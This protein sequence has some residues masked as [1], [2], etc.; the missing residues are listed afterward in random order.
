MMERSRRSSAWQ[1]SVAALERARRHTV[2]RTYA[3]R[4]ELDELDAAYWR[5]GQ[6]LGERA[7]AIADEERAR[8]QRATGRCAAC[9]VILDDHAC[10]EEPR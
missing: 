9:R 8:W 4:L 3:I 10:E 7:I 2:R 5:L 1:P 6:A